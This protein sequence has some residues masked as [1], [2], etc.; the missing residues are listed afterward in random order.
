[1]VGFRLGAERGAKIMCVQ[2][3]QT[4]G[5]TRFENYSFLIEVWHY[6]RIEI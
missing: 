6:G 5:Y 1:M 3:L 4:K 2:Q